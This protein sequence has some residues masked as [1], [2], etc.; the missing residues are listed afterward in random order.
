MAILSIDGNLGYIEVDGAKKLAEEA[1]VEDIEYLIK[2]V[3][4][5]PSVE[6]DPVG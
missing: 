6:M 4:E 3:M 2:A 5:Q 1:T